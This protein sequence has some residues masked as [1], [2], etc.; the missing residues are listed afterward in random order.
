MKRLHYAWAA[1]F[2]AALMMFL[3][4]GL[5]VN[6]FSVYQPYII[7]HNNFTN[8]QGAW[9]VTVRSLSI[10]L[11]TMTATDMARILGLRRSCTLSAILAAA[12]FFLFSVAKSFPVYCAA[13]ALVGVGYSWGGMVP[14]AMI[15]NTWFRERQSF[16][17]GLAT[18]GSGVATIVAPSV[19][20]YL[21]EEH[22]LAR[23]FFVEGVVLFLLG[24]L[25]WLIL[26]DSPESCGLTPYF[27]GGN[28]AVDKENLPPE[29][30]TNKLW[31][32]I[33]VAAF[34]VGPSTSLG[35]SNLG[36]LYS[37]E[38][39][40]SAT[41]ANLIS[42][43]G[44]FLMIGKLIYGQLVDKMGGRRSN[45]LIFVVMLLG[46]LLCCLAGTK[47]VVL[48]YIAM[49]IL[50]LGLPISCMTFSVW[51]RECRGDKGYAKGLKWCQ[52]LF[53]LGILLFGPV[54]G[55]LADRYGSYVPAFA[56]FFAMMLISAVC[57][58]YAYAKSKA[59]G[60]PE[61]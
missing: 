7:A 42:T 5:A 38:G 52:S 11:A 34:F 57:T 58:T 51:V 26:R 49:I 47:S 29:G 39:F 6:V 23:A 14:A 48:A 25:V 45:H 56:M 61:K 55:I 15:I 53:A 1:C 9:I 28:P 30:M 43:M 44:L 18:A 33:L 22:S 4:V 46:F 31:L 41:V 27:K 10:F 40:D 19:L 59:G 32:A 3:V 37:T 35:M 8:T 24:L 60:P 13:A 54:P 20:T 16:A 50:G 2:G 17:L 12:S 36:V 21:I